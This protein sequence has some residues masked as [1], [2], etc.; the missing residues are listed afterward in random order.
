MTLCSGY[1]FIVL[2][3]WHL[4]WVNVEHITKICKNEHKA[5]EYDGGCAKWYYCICFRTT[6]EQYMRYIAKSNTE[7]THWNGYA[8]VV[9]IRIRQRFL[10]F[11][12]LIYPCT[13]SKYW[14]YP[15]QCLVCQAWFFWKRFHGLS[16]TETLAVSQIFCHNSILKRS[17]IHNNLSSTLEP[18][19]L[20]GAEGSM[21]DWL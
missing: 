16:C 5:I 4:G 12:C 10:T 17:L 2:C 9:K 13:K 14:F 21:M 8:K 1:D 19:S 15:Q 20:T 11:F 3:L 6:D 18:V 7:I